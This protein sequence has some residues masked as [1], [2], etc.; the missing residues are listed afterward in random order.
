MSRKVAPTAGRYMQY[1]AMS[2]VGCCL[3]HFS[4]SFATREGADWSC[5]MTPVSD[6]H[7]FAS[8]KIIV[9]V[10]SRHIRSLVC[11]ETHC[12]LQTCGAGTPTSCASLCF[13]AL[14]AILWQQKKVLWSISSMRSN[15]KHSHSRE[16]LCL[17]NA[18]SSWVLVTYGWAFTSQCGAAQL[19]ACWRR[20]D[21]YL[22]ARECQA[23]EELY[24]AFLNNVR[25]PHAFS[26][27][28]HC[29]HWAPVLLWPGWAQ[30]A[31]PSE[32]QC[33]QPIGSASSEFICWLVRYNCY[34]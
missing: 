28:E 12:Q 23:A 21:G 19:R 26:K 7:A 18:L 34:M 14:W 16:Y 22:R 11:L 29:A 6:C 13:N 4:S 8:C 30:T 10:L 15:W 31:S 17:L 20:D 25:Q 2:L 24:N 33:L 32:G 1:E 3:L 5:T 27:A 9:S